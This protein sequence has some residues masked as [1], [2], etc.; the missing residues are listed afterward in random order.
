MKTNNEFR[1]WV[2]WFRENEPCQVPWND[3][4]PLADV[5]RERVQGPLRLFQRGESSDARHLLRKVQRYAYRT[6][7]VDYYRAIEMLI[8]EEHRHATWLGEFMALEDIRPTKSNGLD[9]LFRTARHRLPLPGAIGLLM[10][11]EIIAQ[12]FY[13][14][15]H[16]ATPSAVL[17]TICKQILADEALHLRFQAHALRH[18][19]ATMGVFPQWALDLGVRAA[20][21]TALHL[22]WPATNEL[23]LESGVYFPQLYH[24]CHAQLDQLWA[25]VRGEAP[26]TAPLLHEY[27]LRRTFLQAAC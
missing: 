2:G 12:P 19:R 3:H 20:L 6:G 24:R 13:E 22:L 14:A 8:A 18:F 4:V 10:V 17:K 11:A 15:L 23:F 1:L 5:T 7:Q 16:D 26:L 21:K 27:D 9:T 25:I